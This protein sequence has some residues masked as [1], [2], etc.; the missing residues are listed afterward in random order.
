ME[1]EGGKGIEGG[2]EGWRGRGKGIEGGRRCDVTRCNE[3]RG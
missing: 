3:L 2:R 1:R